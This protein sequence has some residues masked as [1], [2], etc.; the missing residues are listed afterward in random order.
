MTGLAVRNFM[1]E[2][3]PRPASEKGTSWW[4]TNAQVGAVL[5]YSL[6]DPEA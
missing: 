5:D 2:R 3:F 6:N 4:L 1:R